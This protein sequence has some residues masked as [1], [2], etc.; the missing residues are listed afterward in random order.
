MLPKLRLPL[1]ELTDPSKAD[2]T[3]VITQVCEDY[4]DYVIGKMRGPA[5]DGLRVVAG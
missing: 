1:V 2:V 4:A 3:A 5:H